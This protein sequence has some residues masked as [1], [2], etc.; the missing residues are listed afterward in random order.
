MVRWNINRDSME[1]K[2][3]ALLDLM[4]ALKRDVL[5]QV[6]ICVVSIYNV[7]VIEILKCSIDFNP[8]EYKVL[9]IVNFYNSAV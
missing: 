8:S 9:F 6:M 2:Q 4:P 1:D 3:R 7:A 5:H